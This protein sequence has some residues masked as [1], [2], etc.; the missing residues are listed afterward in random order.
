[1]RSLENF[2]SISSEAY[3]VSSEIFVISRDIISFRVARISN[4]CRDSVSVYFGL[5]FSFRVSND[6]ERYNEFFFSLH[7][8]LAVYGCD[9]IKYQLT[10]ITAIT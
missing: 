3:S 1:M 5:W 8:A 10:S 7:G 4:L 2:C 9:M 6:Y